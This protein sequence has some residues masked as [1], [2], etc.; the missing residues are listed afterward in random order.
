MESYKGAVFLAMRNNAS[1]QL[2]PDAGV[3][4]KVIRRRTVDIEDG[5]GLRLRLLLLFGW[6]ASAMPAACPG[7]PEPRK[8]T[9]LRSGEPPACLYSSIRTED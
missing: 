3:L 6:T 4:D 9:S 7:D 2:R 5:V 1:G 8:A